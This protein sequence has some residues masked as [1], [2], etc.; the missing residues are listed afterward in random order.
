MCANTGI[1]WAIG[2]VPL[3]GDLFD[4][5]FKG[6]LRNVGLLKSDLLNGSRDAV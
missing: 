2:A 5:G 1:D 4:I 6:N 3:V